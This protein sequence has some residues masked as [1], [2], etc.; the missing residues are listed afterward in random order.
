MHTPTPRPVVERYALTIDE[1]AEASTLG[2]TKLFELIYDGTLKSKMVG[3]RRLI[4]AK[5]LREFIEG[6]PDEA[7]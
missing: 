1:A 7:A 2:R 3:R 5:S 6:G 4:I